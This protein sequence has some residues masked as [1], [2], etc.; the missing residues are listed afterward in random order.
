[1]RK[2]A[3]LALLV[4]FCYCGGRTSFSPR[5]D[6]ESRFALAQQY[7]ESR[8]YVKAEQEFKRLIFEHPGSDLVDD[9]QYYLAECYFLDEE[10]DLAILEY[11]F[12]I[13]NYRGSPYLDRAY[14]KIGLSYY[15]LSRPYYLDQTSTTKALDEIDLFLAKYP[16][17]EYKDS[18]LTVREK[19][20]EKLAKKD[21]EA[22]NLYMKLNK[23]T[24][25]RVY[26]QAIVEDY[27]GTHISEEALYFIG[28]SYEK[29][30]DVTSA[31]EAYQRVISNCKDE[32]IVSQ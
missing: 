31:R 12:L 15:N 27:P 7:M 20:L 11:T 5:L 18:A 1:M 24:A 16:Q 30:G 28:L 32:H 4:Q 26:F 9:A 3:W 14:F 8:N 2:V 25:A 13:D 29:E 10:Y 22:A 6:P 23:H 21:F 17:S 19:C